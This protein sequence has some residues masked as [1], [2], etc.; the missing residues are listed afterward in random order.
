MAD[1]QQIP[2]WFS[3]AILDGIERLYVLSLARTPSADTIE[4][5]HAQ[6]VEVLWD[7]PVQ[8]D[9]EVDR[10]RL[11]AAFKRLARQVDT[12][13]APSQLWE[14]MPGRPQRPALPGPELTPEQRAR[15]RERVQDLLRQLR[16]DGE[17][18]ADT[19]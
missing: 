9:E 4:L 5:T 14:L 17:A 19:D 15:N 18:P 7:A 6:W 10:P 11:Q 2:D 1:E 12:W 16:G 3:D 8:W 13:P